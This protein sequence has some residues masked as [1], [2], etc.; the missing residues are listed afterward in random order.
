MYGQYCQNEKSYE[1]CSVRN[2][3]SIVNIKADSLVRN[4]QG[5]IYEKSKYIR[6]KLIKLGSMVYF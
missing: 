3:Y 5:Y 4:D 6:H 2:Q 1:P